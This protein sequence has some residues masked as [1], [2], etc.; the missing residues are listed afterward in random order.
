LDFEAKCIVRLRL[1][2]GLEIGSYGPE[3]LGSSKYVAVST[4]TKSGAYIEQPRTVHL[5]ILQYRFL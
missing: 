1:I 5:K 3:G 2:D 4:T